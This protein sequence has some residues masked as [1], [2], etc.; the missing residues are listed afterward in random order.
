MPNMLFPGDNGDSGLMVAREAPDSFFWDLLYFSISSS[1]SM[2]A[3]TSCGASVAWMACILRRRS[4]M[5]SSSGR[6]SLR[7]VSLR[8]HDS[9]ATWLAG[10][11]S[12]CGNA[13]LEVGG[14]EDV[15]GCWTESG[16][17][18]PV[19]DAAAVMSS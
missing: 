4:P 8:V 2:R 12:D 5:P 17:V 13:E 10:V 16:L 3:F 1:C 15:L 6:G 11:V 7:A 9:R 19:S 18:V 14:A